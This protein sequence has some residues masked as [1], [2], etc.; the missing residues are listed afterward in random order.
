MTGRVRSLQ[1]KQQ[2]CVSERD[3]AV[4]GRASPFDRTHCTRRLIEVQRAPRAIGRVRSHVTRCATASART[5]PSC[6]SP[7]CVTGHVSFVRDR[8]RRSATLSRARLPVVWTD[9]MCQP[10]PV[11]STTASGHCFSVRITPDLRL[12]FSTSGVVENSRFTSIKSAESRKACEA[13]GREEPKPLS[14]AQTPP[15]SQMC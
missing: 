5:Y 11:T 7:G 13:G 12:R 8:T 15:P 3:V 2:Q 10:R 14:T 6:C 9:R 4:T 1:D